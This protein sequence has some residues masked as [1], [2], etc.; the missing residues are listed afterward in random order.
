MYSQFTWRQRLAAFTLLAGTF[1]LGFSY[2]EERQATH[3][4]QR[5]CAEQRIPTGTLVHTRRDVYNYPARTT[6]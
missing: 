6:K 3:E 1:A 4:A 2:G 5:E